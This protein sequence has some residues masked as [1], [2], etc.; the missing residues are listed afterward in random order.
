M[1]LFKDIKLSHRL[2][3]S[4]I[5][6][7]LIVALVGFEGVY[8]LRKIQSN[9][10]FIYEKNV[11][12]LDKLKTIE[13]NLS[14]IRY[15]IT[16][17]LNLQ[18]STKINNIEENIRLIESQNE[19]LMKE[20]EKVISTRIEM[21]TF[22][23][24]KT[25]LKDYKKGYDEVISSIKNNDLERAEIYYYKVRE[26]EERFYPL[27]QKMIQANMSQ[28]QSAVQNTHY[29]Y[30]RTSNLMIGGVIIAVA[31]SLISGILIS[32]LI[33]RELK[34]AQR[35]AESLGEG[36]LTQVIDVKRN[37]EI[38]LL[39]KALN[40]SGENI[41]NLISEIIHGT[42]ELHLSSEE[43]ST[44]IKEISLKMDAIN[45]S[46][47]QIAVA[48]E[49]LNTVTQRVNSSTENMQSSS[50]LL[51]GK[52]EEGSKSS[53]EIQSRALEVKDK[54]LTSTKKTQEIYQEKF[55]NIMNAIEQGKVVYKVQSLSETIRNI[56]SQTNLLALNAAIEAAR[57]G[58]HGRGFAVVAGEVRKL[59][60]E[61]SKAAS[62]IQNVIKQ[63]EQAFENLFNNA[64]DILEF[65]STYV[66]SDYNMFVQIGDQYEKDAQFISQMSEEIAASAKAMLKSIKEVGLAIQNVCSNFT[67]S[68]CKL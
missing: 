19:K 44:N 15:Y 45:Q 12:S 56:S 21:D 68:C 47:R 48:S 14:N 63:V 4:F 33:S 67:G 50:A 61:S 30:K 36:D 3:L 26:V 2:I 51:T 6:I 53:Y 49:A 65:I 16:S 41:R 42:E 39:I 32:Y 28:A 38:G 10:T 57:A 29:L 58:E 34:K 9:T 54:G 5:F 64:N 1:R 22:P 25:E 11:T 46:S 60:I 13:L 23:N 31:V 62:D 59:A 43:I 8:S 55:N 24:L 35:F 66:T 37:D 27:L 7:S 20:Y 40:K 17:S 18:D 52:A